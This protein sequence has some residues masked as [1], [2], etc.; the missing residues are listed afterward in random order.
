VLDIRDTIAALTDPV[1]PAFAREF[2]Q[3]AVGGGVPPTSCSTP[4]RPPARFAPPRS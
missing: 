1:D 3:S 2:T 4:H